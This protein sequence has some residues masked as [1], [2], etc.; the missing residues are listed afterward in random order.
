MV[1]LPAPKP[2][3]FGDAALFLDVDGTLAPIAARPQDVGPDARL[4]RVLDRLKEGLDG[5]LAVVSGRTLED[6]DRILEGR[7]VCV[8]AVHGLVRRDCDGTLHLPA[9]HPGMARATAAFRKFAAEDPGLLVEE[10]GPS[11]ALHFRQARARALDARALARR[12][13]EETGLALQE[14]DMVEELRTPGPSKGDSIRDIMATEAF[15]GAV[16]V[17]AG[18]DATDEHGF[19]EVERLGGFGVLVGRPRETHARF[20]LRNVEDVLAWLEAAR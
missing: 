20:G 11:V 2:L 1:G 13:A 19:A 3:R 16:P 12:I 4:T 18:D 17:F 8:S 15:Q 14:G 7:I 9:A 6:I 10:K 5:R